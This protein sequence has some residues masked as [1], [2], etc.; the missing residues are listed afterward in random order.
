MNPAPFSRL[1]TRREILRATSTFAGGALLSQFLPWG[2]VVNTP[3]IVRADSPQASSAAPVDPVAQYRA[4]AAT[5]PVETLKLRDNMY[6]L[7]GP[8]GNIIVLDGP[9]GKMV[10]DTFVSTSWTKLQQTLDGLA[11]PP[12]KLFI[13]THRDSDHATTHGRLHG[14][15]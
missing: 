14:P 9:D 2:M 13:A 6:L 7:A 15:G 8:G 10:V 1:T 11:C 12:P 5:V 4:N 3:A